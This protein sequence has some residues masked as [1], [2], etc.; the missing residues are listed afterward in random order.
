VQSRTSDRA[1][2]I[3]PQV[4]DEA[5]H[6]LDSARRLGRSLLYGSLP[7]DGLAQDAKLFEDGLRV[8][9]EVGCLVANMRRVI[10]NMR[11]IGANVAGIISDLL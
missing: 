1:L 3:L 8:V 9:P 5:L 2:G 6:D 7:C 10:P 4:T 11:C